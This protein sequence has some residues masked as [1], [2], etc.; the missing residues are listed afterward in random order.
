M[1][2]RRPYIASDGVRECGASDE[3]D[4]SL[5]RLGFPSR[6]RGTLGGDPNRRKNKASADR[7]DSQQSETTRP[8]SSDMGLGRVK[9]LC[10]KALELVGVATRAAFFW[11]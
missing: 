5:T 9:T 10:G 7:M 3:I 2:P 8:P 11:L 6:P 4:F 1:Y